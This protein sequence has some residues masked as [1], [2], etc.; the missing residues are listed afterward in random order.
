MKGS[1]RFRFSAVIFAAASALAAGWGVVSAAT[2]DPYLNPYDGN[3]TLTRTYVV[4][5]NEPVETFYL[6]PAET[7]APDAEP[8]FFSAG[9]DADAVTWDIILDSPPSISGIANLSVVSYEIEPDLSY[10]A[11][12]NVSLPNDASFGS[13]SIKFANPSAESEASTTN[14]TIVRQEATPWTYTSAAGIGAWVADPAS[15]A[16]YSADQMVVQNTDFYEQHPDRSFPTGLDGLRH[17]ELYSP[18]SA[19]VASIDYYYVDGIGFFVQSMTVK[20]TEYPTTYTDGW[21]YRVYRTPG[22]GVVPLSEFVG[23][24]SIMLR[25]GDI[26]LWKYGNFNASDLFPNVIVP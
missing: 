1:L 6:S 11:E 8:S 16:V 9:D 5:H 3:F 13:L 14:V 25:S 22:Y 24:D 12:V 4:N 21:Q 18:I 17:A 15:S 26:I 20:G 2:S 19:D 7:I 23:A 10:L